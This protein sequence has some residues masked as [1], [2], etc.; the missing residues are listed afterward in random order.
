VGDVVGQLPAETICSGG[1]SEAAGLSRRVLRHLIVRHDLP[2]GSRILD[3][4]CG[5]GRLVDFL[6]QL[7]FDATGIDECERAIAGGRRH[8]PYLDL[9]HGCANELAQTGHP[10]FDI[11]L[12]RDCGGYD[13][14][15]FSARSLKTTASLLACLRPGGLLAF[16]A[17]TGGHNDNAAAHS[18][19]C[20]DA[21]LAA[22]PGRTETALL[23]DSYA[24]PGTWT[25]LLAGRRPEGYLT[26]TFQIPPQQFLREEWL[27][28]AA[29]ASKLS[30]PACCHA[31]QLARPAA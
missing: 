29:A 31:H 16:L 21:H 23:P 10:A 15:L 1:L 3:V 26:S 6:H 28:L 7:G 20:Y 18:P 25:S 2:V 30:R 8:S 13:E 19:G 12:V 24:R 11:V 14:D 22:F 17:R 4:G 9:R 27:R 5:E